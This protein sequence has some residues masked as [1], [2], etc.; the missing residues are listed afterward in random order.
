MFSTMGTESFNVDLSRRHLVTR[1]KIE[2]GDFRL[3]DIVD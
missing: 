1:G 3:L 2:L